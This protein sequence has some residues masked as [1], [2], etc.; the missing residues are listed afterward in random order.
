M[1]PRSARKLLVTLAV[2]PLVVAAAPAPALAQPATDDDPAP[3]VVLMAAEP[4]AAY[5]GG[6]PGLAATSPGPGEQLDPAAPEVQEYVEHLEREQDEAVA[7]ADIPASAKLESFAY[8]LNGFSAALTGEQ[9]ERLAK[10]K[11]VAAVVRDELRQLQT[12][13]S[14]GFLGLDGRKGPWASGYDGEGV[15]IG[16]V[17]SGI[18]PEHPSFADDGSYPA[19]PADWMGGTVV[20][21]FGDTAH[22]PDDA[23]FACNNKLIGARDMRTLYKT[24]IG[25]EVY[26]SAR[27]YDG[28]GTHTA[29]TAGGNAGVPAEIFGIGRGTV[30]GI[31]PR[32]H[33]AAYSACG[34]LGCFG[35][36]LADAIDAA[37]ADGVD[38]INYSIG[39]G[40]SLTGPDDVAF[41]FAN[42]AGVFSA[43][44]AGNTGPGAGSIGSPANDPWVLTVGA[45]YHDR[46]FESTVRLGNH[47]K[48]S[49]ASITPGTGKLPLVDAEDHG[50]ALC[51]PAVTFDPPVTGA[52]VL[53]A[54]G[55]TARVAKSQ[56]VAEQGGA[57]MILYNEN[58]VQ[59]LVTDSHHV[60][61]VLISFSDGQ[62]V[63]A[64]IDQAGERATAQIS[65][66][67]AKRAKGSI[68]ADFSSRGPTPVAPS[69][70][71]PDVTAPGVNILAGNSPTPT[72]GVSGELFQSISGTSMSSPHAAGVL[73][74][75]KQAHPDWTPAMAQ[76][77]MMT[78]A[79]QDVRK[80]DGRTKADPFDLGAGHIDPSG[81]PSQ[82][83]SLFNPGL[84][85][86]AGF[87][88]YLGFI[89]DAAPE[90]LVDPAG[91]CAALAAAGI[92]TT[93]EN[94]NYP[95]IGAA[96]VPGTIEIQRTITSVADRTV[97][98]KAKVDQPRGY[99]VQVTPS[100][101]RLAPG[102]SAT[103]TIQIT[104]KSA[105]LDEWRFGSLTWK[106]SGYDVRS[107]IA[108]KGAALGVPAEVTGSGTSGSVTF[109]VGF[110]YSGDYTAA[111]HGPA[112]L[113]GVPDAVDQDPDQTFNPDDPAGTTAHEITV[114]DVAYLRLE[115]TTADLTPAD[116][117]IDIDLYLYNSAGEQVATST[118]GGTDEHIDLRLPADDTYTLYVHGWQT[119]G[120]TVDYTLRTWLV[121]LAADTGALQIASA[122]GQ[123]V[124]GQSG[125][126]EA[127]WS[128]LDAGTTYLGAVSHSGPGGLL[129]LTLVAIDTN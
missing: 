117:A 68:M 121:P 9:A 53:C 97:T 27:D 74:L 48:V 95:S 71:K 113:V 85:Y 99:Q 18:W 50:N 108:V 46:F 11:G 98:W 36:D 15:I 55:V 80:E 1:K 19:P 2:S 56:A 63:K 106:G 105:P 49:G 65:Q 59:A 47:R 58:D 86:Q 37:V 42:A 83:G 52:I 7:A 94:L 25:P 120:G 10:Q 82:S 119:L 35:G 69:L 12:D 40:P 33:I 101:V 41:L 128:G 102:E 60:P 62:K 44:S 123:A 76:S 114:S 28:H 20:C 92:P 45:S 57:G 73:A 75:L 110:G 87:N 93:V 3:Y 8:A 77:A 43:T 6:V 24:F 118:A 84:V 89:C 96:E 14:P 32:A 81:K 31:A 30:S 4:A 129:G 91:T 22:N 17:D 21:E 26:N 29:S 115:L 61:S 107:P 72:L 125:T 79:R 5:Q 109:D 23:P 66:G 64:Y 13:A 124:S 39:G 34:E 70:I 112:P 54:R 88:E 111:A 100:K 78:T 51:D 16:V 122:P 104:N 67:K 38:V 126:V 103:V 127:S 90:L 116:P